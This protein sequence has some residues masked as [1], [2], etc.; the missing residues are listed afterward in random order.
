[1]GIDSVYMRNSGKGNLGTVV[2]ASRKSPSLN[3]VESHPVYT[4]NQY[5]GSLCTVLWV[6]R[7][8]PRRNRLFRL[9][10]FHVVDFDRP[11]ETPASY[12]PRYL[13]YFAEDSSSCRAGIQKYQKYCKQTPVAQTNPPP[14]S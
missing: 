4:A 5:K 1:V 3:R 9:E 7:R 2:Y 12:V 10:A 8:N 14:R 13:L 6:S 11:E